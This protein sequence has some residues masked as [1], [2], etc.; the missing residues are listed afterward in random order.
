MDAIQR[1]R[2]KAQPNNKPASN[3]QQTVSTQQQDGKQVIVIAPTEPDTVCAVLRSGR[4]YGAWAYPAYPR[5]H[6]A[7]RDIS[8]RA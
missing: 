6:S 1:L 2:T 4:V 7:R 5:N 3:K 8:P